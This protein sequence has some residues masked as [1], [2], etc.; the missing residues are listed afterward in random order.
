MSIKQALLDSMNLEIKVV[1]H[2][3]SKLKPTE[4][5]Y[6]P[7]AGQRTTLE[8]LRYISYCAVVG[9]KYALTG[10]W[11]DAKAL[12]EAADKHTLAEIPA[13]LDRE[14]AA[15]SDLLAP[16]TDAK[17]LETD[18]TLPSGDKVKLFRAL[19]DMPVKWLTAYKMQLF[20]Y[21][22]QNGH[23]E[24]STPNLWRGTDP[25]PKA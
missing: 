4:A 11:D 25:K 12:H 13:A 15:L 18:S 5:D 21:L 10:K 1:K 20:L 16:L 23:A 8:L 3:A 17:L 22:K 7:S 24:L 14:A 2:L 19:M 6:R 9:T